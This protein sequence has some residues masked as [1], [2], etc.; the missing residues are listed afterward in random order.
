MDEK[1]LVILVVVLFI[2][3]IVL[4]ISRSG[5]NHGR[6][7]PNEAVTEAFKSH[8]PA[9]DLNYWFSGPE[10]RPIA[11]IGVQR[12]FRFDS[13]EHWMRANEGEEA[14]KR[15]IEGMQSGAL[16]GNRNLRG[17]GMVDQHG[18]RI[19]VWYSAVG[20]QAMIKRT[21]IDSIEIWPPSQEKPEP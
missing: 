4:L 5:E 18:E 14:L 16:Q 2:G 9:V 20:I 7:K 6:L 8:R 12:R 1:T 3:F 10:S 15:L 21:G 11:I 19:G 17:F 13:A